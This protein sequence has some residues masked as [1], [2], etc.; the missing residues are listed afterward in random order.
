MVVPRILSVQP[1]VKLMDQLKLYLF[2]RDMIVVGL[3]SD[4]HFVPAMKRLQIKDD[5]DK[6]GGAVAEADNSC[7]FPDRPGEPDCIYYLRTGTCS[8]GSQCR[9]NHPPY[10]PQGFQNSGELPVRDGQPDC[11]VT[12]FFSYYF[13]KFWVS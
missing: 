10:S 4:R 12:D 13:D 9:F 3:S 8:Y 2:L 1:L 6:N 5:G 7:L 11:R